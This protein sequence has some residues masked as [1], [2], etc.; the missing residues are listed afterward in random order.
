PKET[1]KVKEAEEKTAIVTEMERAKKAVEGKPQIAQTIIA[2]E[3]PG[4]K[5]TLDDINLTL[6]QKKAK[7]EADKLYLEAIKEVDAE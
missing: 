2:Q 3:K 7:E 5:S 6:E 4:P 1:P